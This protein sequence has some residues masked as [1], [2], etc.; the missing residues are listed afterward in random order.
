MKNECLDTTVFEGR[1]LCKKHQTSTKNE[2]Y[3]PHV[4]LEYFSV[5]MNKHDHSCYMSKFG[6]F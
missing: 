1:G 4:I 3:L 5:R 6:Y 2:L